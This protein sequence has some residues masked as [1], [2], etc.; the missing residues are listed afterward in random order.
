MMP[1]QDP[2]IETYVSCS[3][4][5]CGNHSWPVE[6]ILPMPAASSGWIVQKI[7]YDLNITGGKLLQ[8]HFWEGF[9]VKAGATTCVYAGADDTY[10]DD[11][12][13]HPSNST[14]TSKTMGKAKF[15]EG[16]LPAD[17]IRP[18]PA[19]PQTDSGVRRSTT[20]QPPFWDDTGTAHDLT[21]TWDCT[22]GND[23]ATLLS[24]PDPLNVCPKKHPPM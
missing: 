2:T 17:F 4:S 23:T 19:N 12:D 13:D 10:M 3:L 20:I 6:F 1:S 8:S 9:Y 11:P 18:D 15:Y 21:V 22:A 24:T 5:T 16:T 7:S 14:G